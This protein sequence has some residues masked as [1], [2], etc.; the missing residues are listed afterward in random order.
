MLA[1]FAFDRRERQIC[2][3]M[4]ENKGLEK[5]RQ[6]LCPTHLASCLDACQLGILRSVMAVLTVDI[7]ANARRIDT[8]WRRSHVLAMQTLSC[9]AEDEAIW[10]D[11]WDDVKVIL[12]QDSSYIAVEAFVF[13]DHLVR[14]EFESHS[15]DPLSSVDLSVP[16]HSLF[17]SISIRTRKGKM[18]LSLT[19]TFLGRIDGRPFSFSPKMSRPWSEVP[20]LNHS[21]FRGNAERS[22]FH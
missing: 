13:G 19:R 1:V 15:S 9:R 6:G 10:V 17:S 20:E 3:C 18:L 5:S 14:D 21:E 2:T 4:I 16:N 12:V 7:H 8:S 11:E 22:S